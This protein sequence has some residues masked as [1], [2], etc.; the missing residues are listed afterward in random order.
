MAPLTDI[1][2]NGNEII[3][4]TLGNSMNQLCKIIVHYYKEKEVTELLEQLIKNIGSPSPPIRRA[5][6]SSIIAICRNYHSEVPFEFVTYAMLATIIPAKIED[7]YEYDEKWISSC[8]EL[9]IKAPKDYLLGVLFCLLQLCRLSFEES[10]Q[11]LG[12]HPISSKI[13]LFAFFG[14][15]SLFHDDHNI[16]TA[17]LEL[18]QQIFSSYGRWKQMFTKTPF[19]EKRG[20]PSISNDS[21]SI[22][23]IFF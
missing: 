20:I 23:L 2:L 6:A 14:Y 15:L 7:V 17:G 16:V 1:I 18:L 21:S 9:M 22:F 11:L 4:E 19:D 8:K 12:T 5:T 13:E 10:E 3:Q